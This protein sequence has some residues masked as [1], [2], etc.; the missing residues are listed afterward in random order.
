MK[1]LR[2]HV[3]TFNMLSQRLIDLPAPINIFL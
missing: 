2:K 3:P 1:P